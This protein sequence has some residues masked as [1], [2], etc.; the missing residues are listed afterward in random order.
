M[1]DAFCLL[2]SLWYCLPSGTTSVS[3]SFSHELIY[4][5]FFFPASFKLPVCPCVWLW[6][7]YRFDLQEPQFSSSIKGTRGCVLAA[8]QI[9]VW[10]YQMQLCMKWLEDGDKLLKYQQAVLLWEIPTL[11][12][13][14]TIH[15]FWKTFQI[16]KEGTTFKATSVTACSYEETPVLTSGVLFT[17]VGLGN[18]HSGLNQE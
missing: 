15:L 17:P 1:W 14:L 5:L 2:E 4:I 16:Y 8:S 6:Q 10:G 18:W 3:L 12:W 9:C 7:A 11:L 13:Y